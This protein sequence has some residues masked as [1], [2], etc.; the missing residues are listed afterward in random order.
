[1]SKVITIVPEGD[2]RVYIEFQCNASKSTNQPQPGGTNHQN[3]AKW[4]VHWLTNRQIMSHCFR[5]WKANT[6]FQEKKKREFLYAAYIDICTTSKRKSSTWHPLHPLASTDIWCTFHLCQALHHPDTSSGPV[7]FSAQIT[8]QEQT[9]FNYWSEQCLCHRGLWVSS[10]WMR[11]KKSSNHTSQK[12]IDIKMEMTQ[13]LLLTR[14]VPNNLPF[15]VFGSYS[16]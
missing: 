2:T 12:K 3:E 8:T 4:C 11:K 5:T 13:L 14:N 7:V 6:S 10:D 1:M 9:R 15:W 16:A